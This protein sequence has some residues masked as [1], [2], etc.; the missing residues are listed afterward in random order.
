VCEGVGFSFD[1]RDNQDDLTMI[2]F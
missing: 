2:W 1:D